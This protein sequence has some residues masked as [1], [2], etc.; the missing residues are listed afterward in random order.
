MKKEFVVQYVQSITNQLLFETNAE[1][2]EAYVTSLG[3]AEDVTVNGERHTIIR[4]D[5]FHE[6]ERIVLR[7]TLM[8]MD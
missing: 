3:Y 7:I 2:M 6:D 8:Y 4:R 1:G 5:I